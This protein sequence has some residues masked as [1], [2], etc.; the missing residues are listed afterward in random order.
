MRGKRREVKIGIRK[1]GKQ[2]KKKKQE[3][4]RRKENTGKK[5]MKRKN[6][7][8]EEGKKTQEIGRRKEKQEEDLKW[9]DHSKNITIFKQLKIPESKFFD[10]KRN[11][12]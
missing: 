10:S 1:K 12:Q 2:E 7:K 4:G 9:Y 5:K 11:H 8:E 6:R 3:R